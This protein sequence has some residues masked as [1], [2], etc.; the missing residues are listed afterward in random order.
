MCVQF[1]LMWSTSD[2][3]SSEVGYLTMHNSAR[4]LRRPNMKE[5]HAFPTFD[6]AGDLSRNFIDRPGVLHTISACLEQ[7]AAESAISSAA[8]GRCYT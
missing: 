7:T 5:G 4:R 3:F 1:R 8:Q 6:P 2:V